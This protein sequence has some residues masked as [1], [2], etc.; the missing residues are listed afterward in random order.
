M[1][2]LLTEFFLWLESLSPIQ[3]FFAIAGILIAAVLGMRYLYW[4]C[5]YS[6]RKDLPPYIEDDEAGYW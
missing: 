6:F 3:E 2:K 5:M 4:L 1:T